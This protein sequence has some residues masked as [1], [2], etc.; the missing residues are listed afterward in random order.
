MQL[1]FKADFAFNGSSHA[2]QIYNNK[3]AV[4]IIII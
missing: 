2:Q 4:Y 1:P 3:F